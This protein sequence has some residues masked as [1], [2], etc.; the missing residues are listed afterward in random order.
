MNQVGMDKLCGPHASHLPCRK[1]EHDERVAL[2]NQVDK[3]VQRRK[4][5]SVIRDLPPAKTSDGMRGWTHEEGNKPRPGEEIPA[6]DRQ[7]GGGH[8]KD[9]K[10][11]PAEFITV[12]NIGFL[13]GCVIKRVCRW[14]KKDGL[15]DLEK[16]IHELQL[17]IQLNEGAK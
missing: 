2:A 5:E 1:C 12:N 14:R 4:L 6:L 10:I 11:Q 9:M 13:E 7:V 3:E 17:L 15:K 8:Y 16:A